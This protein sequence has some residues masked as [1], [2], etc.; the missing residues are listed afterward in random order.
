MLRVTSLCR[1]P[2]QYQQAFEQLTGEREQL[3]RQY[4][5]A[6]KQMQTEVAAL[7]AQVLVYLVFGLELNFE[8]LHR[9]QSRS[10]HVVIPLFRPSP[11]H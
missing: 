10:F 3:S 4:E 8:K 2:F 9:F 6:N 7:S 11:P 1:S 5:D